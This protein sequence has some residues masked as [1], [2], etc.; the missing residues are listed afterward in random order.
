M[1]VQFMTATAGRELNEVVDLPD[2]EA[3]FLIAQGAVRKAGSNEDEPAQGVLEGNP[4]LAVVREGEVH[5]NVPQRGEHER[6]VDIDERANPQSGKGDQPVSEEALRGA[7]PFEDNDE[8]EGGGLE[9]LTTREL[10]SYI[11]RINDEHPDAELQVTGNKAELVDRIRTFEDS[12][13]A[14]AGSEQ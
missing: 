9:T 3:E 5:R 14:S 10:K 2:H 7:N 12:Q 6:S 4:N 11:E 13:R 1:E 8:S